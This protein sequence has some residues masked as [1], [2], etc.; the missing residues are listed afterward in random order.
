[1]AGEFGVMF[2]HTNYFHNLISHITCMFLL[3]FVGGVFFI[4]TGIR[5]LRTKKVTVGGPRPS[6]FEWY[7]PET[8]KGAR[9][10]IFGIF[11]VS[12]GALLFF[13]SLLMLFG[14]II[15]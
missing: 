2:I 5:I 8:I 6:I 4:I 14:D 11:Y 7:E 9:S 12:F 13:M 3:C 15:T 10:R 1:M